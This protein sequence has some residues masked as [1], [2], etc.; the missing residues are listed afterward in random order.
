MKNGNCGKIN[1][2]LTTTGE[3]DLPVTTKITCQ[4]IL[5]DTKNTSDCT[6]K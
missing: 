3:E 5:L 1:T 6:S 4:T 2:A